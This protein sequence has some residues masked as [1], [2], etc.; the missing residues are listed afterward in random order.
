[1]NTRYFDFF[2]GPWALTRVLDYRKG[3][4]GPTGSKFQFV[5]SASFL[6]V[7]SME[8]VLLY[9]EQGTLYPFGDAMKPI[10]ASRHYL[11]DFGTTIRVYF[12]DRVEPLE[13]G[14]LFHTLEFSG[15]DFRT[16]FQTFPCTS[17]SDTNQNVTACFE[18]LCLNDLY[19]GRFE[20][21]SPSKFSW[22]WAITGP[23]KDGNIY[24]SYE[25]D[26][27]INAGL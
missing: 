17:H 9:K 21:V 23:Q 5:G 3:G 10:Q 2:R 12:V 14:G 8:N 20:I 13:R 27:S 7:N 4:I 18:H 1:M 6:P 26:V 11:F 24:S 19:K 25:R 16:G 15:P 22:S